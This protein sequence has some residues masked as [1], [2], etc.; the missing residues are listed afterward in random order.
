MGDCSSG[1][2][3]TKV[4]PKGSCG[5]SGSGCPCG[6]AGCDGDPLNC[7]TAMWACSFMTAMKETQVELIKARVK[8]A[9]GPMMEKAADAMVEAMG[10]KWQG[11]VAQS[12]PKNDFKQ[13]LWSL[14]QE[15]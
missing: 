13:K 11:M 14:W 4:Q 7:S 9:W 3:E 8:K 15:K 5:P 6:N 12:K 1:P 2:C 10:E